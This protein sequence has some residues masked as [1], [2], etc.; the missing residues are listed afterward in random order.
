MN[1]TAGIGTQLL[2]LDLDGDGDV[3]LATAGKSGVHF[4][5]DLKVDRVPKSTRE[6][7]KLLDKTW[8]FPGEG[9]EVQQEDGPTPK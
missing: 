2:A 3:D 6:E 8:P 9:V 5:E 7:E 1:G 4:F